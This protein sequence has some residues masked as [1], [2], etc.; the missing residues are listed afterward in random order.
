VSDE[1]GRKRMSVAFGF[2]YSAACLIK[3]STKSFGILLVGRVLSGIATSLLFSV[4]EAWMVSEHI[5]RGYDSSWM[6]ETFSQAIFGN[7][8]A[9]I[10]AGVVASFASIQYGFVTP[11]LVSMVFLLISAVY[12]YANWGENFGDSKMELQNVFNGG[13]AAIKKDSRIALLGSMQSLFEG[14]MYVFVFMWTPILSEV[15]KE[16]SDSSLGLHGLTFASFMVCIM[17]GSC[18]Y[19]LL[20]DKYSVETMYT[21]MLA[22]S[23]VTFFLVAVLSNGFL[24]F[25]TFMVFETMCGLHFTTIGMLR[26]KYIPEDCRAA[27]MNLFR[28]PL[29]LLVV[30]VLIFIERFDNHTV[31]VICGFWLTVAVF[32][33]YRLMQATSVPPVKIIDIHASDDS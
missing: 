22:V 10:M 3:I 19:G 24:I 5:S 9:A 25:L 4:F 27:V 15:V 33:A 18:F 6:G 29:N 28:V 7:G 16:F 2:I 32:A 13:F 20:R 31:F 11:F 8:I 12:V 17:I 1:Y 23:A 21:G 14:S 26:G 30:L